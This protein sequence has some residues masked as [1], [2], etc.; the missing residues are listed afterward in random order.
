[1]K[2]ISDEVFGPVAAIHP[3][4]SDSEALSLMNASPYG[5][6]ASL[7][8]KDLEAAESLATQLEVGT[9]FL[10]RCD[11][12]DPAL[13]WTGTKASGRGYALSEKGFEAF[14]RLKSLHFRL[15]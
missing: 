6:T 14:V 10:N 4:E 9:V 15:P 7:W 13:V 3:V 2:I 1:M 8:T 5:L 11:Y 12:L